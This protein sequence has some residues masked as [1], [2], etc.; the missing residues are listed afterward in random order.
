M[1]D[2]QNTTAPAANGTMPSGVVTIDAPPLVLGTSNTDNPQLAFDAPSIRTPVQAWNL[3]KATESANKLRS[4][5][6]TLMELEYTGQPPYSQ[7]GQ[8]ER[9]Q[10]WESNFNTG[11]L[12]GIVDRKTL[13]FSN[14]ITGQIYLTRSSLPTTW[15]D[16][17]NKSDLFDIHTTRLIQGWDHYSTFVSQS[18][19]ENVLHGYGYAVFLDP[20][21]WTP[22]FFKQDLAYV[23]DESGQNARDLQFFVIKQDYLLYDFIK[24]FRDEGAAAEM[25]Y[26]VANCVRAAH[27]SQVKDPREDQTTT[28]F[29][30]FAEFAS[31]GMLGITYA[32]SGPR[33]VKTYL[34]WNQE[35]DGSVSFWIISRDDG[36]LL[37]FAPKIYKNFSEVTTLFSFQPGNGHLHSSKGLGRMLIGSVKAAEKVRNKQLD[38]TF[39]AGMLIIKA[40]T[41]DRNKIQPVVHAPFIVMDS[42]VEEMSQRFAINGDDFAAVD[43]QVQSWIAQAGSVFISD[44]NDENN[45]PKTATE[46]SIEAKQ[47]QEGQDITESRWINQFMGLVQTMQQR[48]YSNDH[49]AQAEKLFTMIAAGVPETEEFYDQ[50]TGDR[51]CVA[52][53]VNLLKDGLTAEEIKILRRAPA[54][55]YAHTDDAITSQG[56]LAVKKGF[57]GNPNIDQVE[58]DRRAVEALAGPDAAKALCLIEPDQTILAEATRMQQQESVSMAALMQPSPVSPRDN[59][60]LHGDVCIKILQ[61]LGQKITADINAP[62]QLLQV[63]TLN[64]NHLGDHLQQY[65]ERGGVTQNGQYKLL[66]DFYGTFKQSL[67]GAVQLRE[68][69]A[70]AQQTHPAVGAD[71]V[72]KTTNQPP[73]VDGSAAVPGAISSGTA[74]SVDV[75]DVGADLGFASRTAVGGPS[76]VKE[77]E[78]A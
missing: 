12:Q 29:R 78:M 16:F 37:R 1:D 19:K 20:F 68:A 45:K 36:Q 77:L 47:E 25:G 72:G 21:T 61:G 32:A 34:L 59:H 55:G 39:M 42:S 2:A 69:H 8:I 64:L 57:T 22:K 13:R 35:Y 65:L 46:V 14:A 62:E 66:N 28:Q 75:P 7:A 44:N 4:E 26:D 50:V 5:R 3:C 9:A 43:Q 54:I 18:A 49:L 41:K 63:A 33:V 73:P 40:P 56:I 17:K 38:N 76:E 27:A 60:L 11:I 70:V 23:P 51:Q 58:M 71:I 53:I 15:P 24:L 52:T 10:S 6:A 31:D 48:A 67:V 30:K 74:Q